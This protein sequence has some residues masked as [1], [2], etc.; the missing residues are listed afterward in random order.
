MVASG[1]VGSGRKG[2]SGSLGWTAPNGQGEG[3]TGS[4]GPRERNLA[5]CPEGRFYILE[6]RWRE[7]IPQEAVDE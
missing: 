5:P 3:T 4:L 6:K 1:G 7:D 2:R